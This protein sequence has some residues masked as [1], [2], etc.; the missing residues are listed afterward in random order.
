M[1]HVT[2]IVAEEIKEGSV[3]AVVTSD[4]AADGYSLVKWSGTSYTDQETGELLCEGVS[5][6]AG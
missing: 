1:G 6:F 4:E 3:S 2:T 5:T